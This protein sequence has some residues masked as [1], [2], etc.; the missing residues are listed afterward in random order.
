MDNAGFKDMF[1]MVLKSSNLLPPLQREIVMKELSK[2]KEMIFEN[3]PPRIMVI[4]RRGAGKSS[5]INAIFREPVAGIG[6]VLSET[7]K[8]AWHAF[9]NSKGAIRI[10]DTRGIGDRSRPESSNFEHA[11]DEIEHEIEKECPDAVLF[12]CKAKEIDARI[13]EDLDNVIRIKNFVHD[14]HNYQLPLVAVVTQIDE[15]DPKRVEPPYRDDQKQTNIKAAVNAMKQ[16]MA[17]S[18]IEVLKIIPVSAYAEYEDGKRVYDNFFNI[19]LLV[20]YLMEVLPNTA[21]LQLA[22]LSALRKAQRKLARILVASTAT[23]NS[24]IAA[25]PI[26]VADLIPITSAQVSMITGIAFISGRELSKKSALEFLSAIGVNIGVGLAIREGARALVKF[27]FPGAGNVVSA[28]VA[29][30]GTWAVGEAAMAYFIDH[31]TVEEAKQQFSQAKKKYE[32]KEME[33]GN[34]PKS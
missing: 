8:A 9:E 4:G 19:D 14:L 20:E 26:P 30:A 32:Q 7:G 22:R 18:G 12:L 11:I 15:L 6:A 2:I 23:I 31:A 29:F 10:L 17:Q 21:Q 24:A 25:T 28:S 34:G 27:I 33:N 3:R 16:V 13:E 1:G 5:L